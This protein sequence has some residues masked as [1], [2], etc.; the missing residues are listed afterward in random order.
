M[1]IRKNT[2]AARE[3]LA[4]ATSAKVYTLGNYFIGEEVEPRYAADALTK[5]D[6]AKLVTNTRGGHTVHVH[7]NLWY[8][9]S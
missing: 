5:Y 7:S 1:T 2:R 3:I 8:E 4:A 9:L 6:F